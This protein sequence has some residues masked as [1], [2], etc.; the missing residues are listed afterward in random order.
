[1]AFTPQSRKDVEGSLFLVKRRSQPRFQF[2]ILNKKSAGGR[3]A[4]FGVVCAGRPHVLLRWGMAGTRVEL[5]PGPWS[6]PVCL[7]SLVHTHSV[8]LILQP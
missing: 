3:H 5:L 4:C 7:L 8:C 6:T 2:I 1:M